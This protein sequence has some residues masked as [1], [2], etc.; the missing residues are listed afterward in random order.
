MKAIPVG[1]V[2]IEMFDLRTKNKVGG[3]GGWANRVIDKNC[4]CP[5]CGMNL[6]RF[7]QENPF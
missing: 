5:F 7:L 4:V 6:L 3:A 2:A 1:N